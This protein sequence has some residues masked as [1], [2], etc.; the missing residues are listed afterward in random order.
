LVSAGYDAH[1]ADPLGALTLLDSDGYFYMT[2]VLHAIAR[3]FAEGRIVFVLEGGY[4]FDA[5]AW[6]S[7]ATAQALLGNSKPDDPVG[8]AP[9]AERDITDLIEHL[10]GV[11]HLD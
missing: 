5:L 10:K 1:W 8:P 4:N 9:R 7:Y 2:Q 6:S 3:E 11:H